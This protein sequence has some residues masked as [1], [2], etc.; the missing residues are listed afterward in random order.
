MGDE[1]IYTIF[2][3]NEASYSV[4]CS[5]SDLALNIQ[6]GYVAVAGEHHNGYLDGSAVKQKPPQPSPYHD[7]DVIKKQWLLPEDAAS[8][9][10]S[11]AQVEVRRALSK[12]QSEARS[13]LIGLSDSEERD[14]R[15]KYDAA[16][17]ILG[18]NATEAD[19]ALI[20]GEV[21]ARNKYGFMQLV[22]VIIAKGDRTNV[23]LN[24]VKGRMNGFALRINDALEISTTAEE[25][26]SRTRV[27]RDE[28]DIAV[29]QLLAM[30]NDV[31]V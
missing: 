1:M 30:K 23:F 5:E 20:A 27:I 4:T 17:R 15:D 22:L 8:R 28:A 25:L 29:Q 21:A 26:F 2:I 6:S 24:A 10:L 19:N 11:D 31:S 12:Y 14:L 7:W 9:M 18:G 3:D 16:R 13:K